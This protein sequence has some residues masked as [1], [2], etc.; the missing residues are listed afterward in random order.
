MW[1]YLVGTAKGDQVE[2]ACHVVGVFQW[3]DGTTGSVRRKRDGGNQWAGRS[4][5]EATKAK[6]AA[7]KRAWWESHRDAE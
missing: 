7:S 1:P 2:A 5:S 3:I 4:H 6:M